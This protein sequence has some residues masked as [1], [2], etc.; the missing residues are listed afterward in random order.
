MHGR[1]IPLILVAS[2]TPAVADGVAAELRRQGRVVCVAHSA[3][4]CLRVATSVGPDIVLLDPALPS[5]L[6]NLLR[7]HPIT[8]H[9]E[10][11][12]LSTTGAWGAG[13]FARVPRVAGPHA[14]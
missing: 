5:R 7:A 11:L 8:A 4:G 10:V 9:S 13:Q 1:H 6:E 14:A 2:E 12:H 3:S